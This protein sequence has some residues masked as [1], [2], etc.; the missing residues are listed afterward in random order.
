MRVVVLHPT[1]EHVDSALYWTARV[2]ERLNRLHD[3]L[4]AVAEQVEETGVPD[5]LQRDF[6]AFQ[7][8][9]EEL[10]VKFGVPIAAGG[11][12]GRGGFGGR[13]G[14]SPANVLARVGQLK[15]EILS[16]W[17]PPS[18]ALMGRYYRVRP[19]LEG[20]LVE[21]EGFL[22]RAQALADRLDDEGISL[23]VPR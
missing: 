11:G 16:F 23:T 18:D 7:E 21:A 17:E 13:G 12:R 20:A 15:G 6:E 8:A 2:Y 4:S 14:G 9:W 5:G 1:S 19:E 3:A 22:V 10:R